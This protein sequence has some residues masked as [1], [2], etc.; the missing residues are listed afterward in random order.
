MSTYDDASLIYYPS[1]YKA[2]KAYSLKPTDGSGDLTF[3]RAS[4][5]TRVNESGLIEEVAANVPRL[6]NSQGGCSSLL[7]EPQ[8][9][10]LLL[11]S[12]E[13]NTD[14]FIGANVLSSNV[15]SSPVGLINA[16]KIA[17]NSANSSHFFESV[18]YSV[19][20][21]STYTYSCF[22]KSAGSNFFQ[23]AT[24]TGFSSAYQNFNLSNGT[25][26]GGNVA[27]FG[28]SSSIQ[29]Y[30]NGWYRV[31]LTATSTSTSARFLC[32]TILA[33]VARNA[34]FIGNNTDGIYTFGHQKELGSYPT[35]Y[36]PTL[37]TAVTRVADSATKTGIS[38]LIGQTEGTIFIDVDLNSRGGNAYFAIAPN[39]LATGVYICL[40]YTS[41]SP[42]DS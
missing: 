2:S 10:N 37:G 30:G 9:S 32:V 8:R 23:L 21:S 1:G 19:T 42:R 29:S 31:S 12:E 34:P 16:S 25:L 14:W 20:T 22:V 7:L 39:L 6:D 15:S 11:R 13:F 18:I 33:D 41:P 36:I 26:A 38:S 3:T 17:A 28:Y 27:S 5:A 35:S 40:L 24:S 4:T